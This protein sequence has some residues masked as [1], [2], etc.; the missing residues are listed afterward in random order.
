M[1]ALVGACSTPPSLMETPALLR[2]QGTANFDKV[3]SAHQ[4][5][6][7]EIFYATDRASTT[8]EDGLEYT[9]QRGRNLVLGIAKVEIGQGLLSWPSLVRESLAEA[10]TAAL[11]MKVV[12]REEVGTLKE[13]IFFLDPAFAR[14]ENEAEEA[15]FASRMNARLETSRSQDVYVFVSPFKHSFDD[16]AVVAAEFFHFMGRDGAF[17]VYSWPSERS[18][19]SYF[20][21][22][23]NAY[24]TVRSLRELIRFLADRTDAR[25]IHLMTYSAGARVLS[26]ALHGLRLQSDAL[27]EVTVREKFRIGQVI[28]TGPDLDSDVFRN[29]YQDGTADLAD[30]ITIYT[31]GKDR[32][33]R[34][35]RFVFGGER[36]GSTQA[37]SLRA[38]TIDHLRKEE[39]TNFVIVSNTE[40]I[41]KDNSHG[42]Y[43]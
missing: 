1:G 38:A 37:K 16:S 10:R 32:A 21:A 36:L 11:P 41:D 19:L 3:P 13:S 22:T 23:E 15:A 35:A 42:Y 39:Q 18:N 26:Y 31:T 43:R 5:D 2:G 14:E 33:L 29:Q 27:D 6:R 40:R 9:G 28:C 25:E 12:S 7:V 8:S 20:Q 30:Q 17:M 4:N 24:F 34:T